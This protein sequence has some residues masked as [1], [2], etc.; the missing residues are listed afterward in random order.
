MVRPGIILYG[1]APSAEPAGNWEGSNLAPVIVEPIMELVSRIV[2]IKKVNK[3][4][5]VSYGRTW[6]ALVD[7]YIATISV[8]YGDGLP[9][10]LGG[11]FSVRIR[12]RLY[13]LV[14]RMC[15]DQ[16]M[17]NLG[18]ET[19]IKRWE[20][21]TIFGGTALS[22][23]DIAQELDTIPYEITCGINKRV[24]RLYKRSSQ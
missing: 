18:P 21:V 7:S 8:G 12:D 22:A 6:T 19:D 15:M 23:A 16:C 2:F 11:Y 13:P 9:R 24:P 14:G 10:S 20:E 1:Y 3:G 17:V 5:P 4:E